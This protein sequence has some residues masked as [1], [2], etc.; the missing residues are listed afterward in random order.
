MGLLKTLHKGLLGRPV[1][2]FQ[3]TDFMGIHDI[4]Y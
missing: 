2:D 1:K 4:N 3:S